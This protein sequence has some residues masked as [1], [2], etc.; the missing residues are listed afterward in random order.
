MQPHTRSSLFVLSAVATQ[1]SVQVLCTKVLGTQSPEST[2]LRT[3][4][5][6]DQTTTRLVIGSHPGGS[7]SALA[8]TAAC[9]TA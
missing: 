9:P 8:L 3:A 6:P 5:R 1:D 2:L 7:Q 4:P